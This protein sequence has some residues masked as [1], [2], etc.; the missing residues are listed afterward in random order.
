[1][2]ADPDRQLPK[3]PQPQDGKRER[4][5]MA[6]LISSEK[7]SL[8]K[9]SSPSPFQSSPTP[10]KIAKPR[11]LREGPL[12]AQVDSKQTS[13]LNSLPSDPSQLPT[14]TA[15]RPTSRGGPQPAQAPTDTSSARGIR[16][17][18]RRLESLSSTHAA[19]PYRSWLSELAD[20]TQWPMPWPTGGSE[21]IDDG[22]Q[23]LPVRHRDDLEISLIGSSFCSCISRFEHQVFQC[24]GAENFFDNWE[25][26][27]MA[28]PNGF[29]FRTEALQRVF[30][31]LPFARTG[32]YTNTDYSNPSVWDALHQEPK[33]LMRF[34][35]ALTRNI[36]TRWDTRTENVG[37]Q[38]VAGLMGQAFIYAVIFTELANA[39]NQLQI[40]GGL[41]FPKDVDIM[42]RAAE[43]L[44]RLMVEIHAEYKEP[45]KYHFLAY[46]GIV[47]DRR[48]RVVSDKEFQGRRPQPIE[49]QGDPFG[50]MM[51]KVRELRERRKTP[52]LT[53]GSKD[54]NPDKEI[55][56]SDK[57]DMLF[58][59]GN[60]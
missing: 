52:A 57:G 46:T 60:G 39:D 17:S 40:F 21:F 5:P 20:S 31:E 14:D 47:G 54:S 56:D 7:S 25:V 15:D 30:A 6:P 34:I 38:E 43:Q 26:T 12:L 13:C 18:P 3:P 59:N 24:S 32:S 28:M 51:D 36:F 22:Y 42:M 10:V 27:R 37:R 2:A 35:W 49:V 41:I 19:N 23:V 44:R 1:M 8:P 58:K 45:D 55:D 16:S 48:P 9:S 11:I 29:S 53:E 50:A 33:V 4:V